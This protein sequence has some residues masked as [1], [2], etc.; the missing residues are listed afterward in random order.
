MLN[1]GIFRLNS[2]YG[3][4]EMGY[5]IVQ[6]KEERNYFN[7]GDF[8]IISNNNNNNNN[9]NSIYLNTIKNSAKVDVVVYGQ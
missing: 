4:V 5:F 8:Q 1:V 7:T 6:E 3:V 9:S 2:D